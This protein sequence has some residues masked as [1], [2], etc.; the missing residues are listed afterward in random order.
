[1]RAAIVPVAEVSEK[2]CS[3]LGVELRF[4]VR[5]G[6]DEAT[7]PVV[8]VLSELARLPTPEASR[9]DAQLEG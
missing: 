1:V 6:A 7:V 5:G 9:G 2:Q 4:T 3:L 8:V